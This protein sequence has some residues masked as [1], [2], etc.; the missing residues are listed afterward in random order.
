ML[1]EMHMC[2]L[3]LTSKNKQ[4]AT[5]LMSTN[6]SEAGLNPCFQVLEK[7]ANLSF[8]YLS[9]F[10]YLSNSTV[11]STPKDLPA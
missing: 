11:N 3:T 1:I 8:Q 2:M 4:C 10:I 9:Q 5:P 7:G 6:S